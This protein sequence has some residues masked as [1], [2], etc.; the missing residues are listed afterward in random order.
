MT[1]SQPTS[2]ATAY[3]RNRH[4]RPLVVI[5]VLAF[6]VTACLV[7]GC[8]TAE[9]G[10][11]PIVRK[12][13]VDVT[14]ARA[15]GRGSAIFTR[16]AESATRAYADR[17]DADTASF[18]ASVGALQSDA[19]SGGMAKAKADEIAAQSAYD[20][21]RALDAQNSINAA[22]LD[23][24]SSDVGSDESF[25]GLH[26][27]ERD[28]WTSGPLDADVAAL[29]GQAPAARFLLSR[30]RLGPEAIGV[31][32]VDQLDWVVDVALPVSQEQY[33]HL[34]LVDVAATESAARSSFATIQPLAQL[35][36]PSLAATVSSQFATLDA[37]VE[38]LGSPG[39]TPDTTVTMA[40]RLALSTQ[41]DATA[42]TLAQLSARLT[43]YG[44][45]GA[46][47]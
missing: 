30:E 10:S 27:I 47:S 29:A 18:V 31:V 34:G 42:S 22:S 44:T 25:G 1:P 36:D 13:G 32:A 12:S 6:L 20:G 41:L 24:L 43:P 19:A 40:A 38:A 45:A 28:L 15:T 2:A 37:M 14:S 17:V 7:T 39:A 8:S 5:P 16:A 3:F 33:S 46:P 23:E 35:V 4:V 9:R 11:T 26:A 21:F